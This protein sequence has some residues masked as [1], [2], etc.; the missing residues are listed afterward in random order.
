MICFGILRICGGN[1]KKRKSG[2]SVKIGLLRCNV[3]N[4]RRGV[5]L[6]QGMGHPHRG[7]AEVPKWHPSGTPRRS[8][9]TPQHN[10]YA[11]RAIFRF[12]FPNTSYSYTDSLKTLINY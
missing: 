9:A 7:E 1:R 10:Y 4:P 3:G 11:Q 5:D 8:N 12:L 6:R 2:K